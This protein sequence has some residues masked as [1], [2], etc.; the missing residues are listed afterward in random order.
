M[1][2]QRDHDPHTYNIRAYAPGEISITVP[3]AN[4]G[5]N[6]GPR[7]METIL[8]SCVIAPQQILPDWPPQGVEELAEEHLTD[9]LQLDPE[10][11]IL[12]TGEQLQFPSAR[13]GAALIAQQIG[14]EVMDTAAA[15]RTYNILVAEGRKVVA[16]LMNPPA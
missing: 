13:L 8:G 7:E 11:V 14:L 6:D 10:L 3:V 5:G 4:Q 12:G 16:A 2:F 15:C 1:Q 9:L